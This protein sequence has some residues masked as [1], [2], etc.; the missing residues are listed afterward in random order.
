MADKKI[1]E[2]TAGSAVSTSVVPVSDAAGTATT[3]VT[4][5]AIAALGGGA[6]AAHA[7]THQVGGTDAV[8]NVVNSPSSIGSSQNNYTM[9]AADIVRLT[10]SAA[11][12]ITGF[13]AG[14]SGDARLLINVG[15]YDITIKHESTSS[16]AANRVTVPWAGDCI[17]AASGGAAT[18]VYDATTSR[19]R[20]A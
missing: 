16:T 18:L 7:S 15:S 5:A 3:K 9:P 4:L 1:S 10:S 2:L 11:Y 14:A 13:V 19:W 8:A 12:N 17:L 20:V 6:P